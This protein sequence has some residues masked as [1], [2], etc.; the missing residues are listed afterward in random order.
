MPER[1]SWV[2][3]NKLAVG[4]FP[5]STTSAA[6]LRRQGI[7]AVLCLTEEAERAVPPEILH[8]FVWERV[9]IPDGAAGGIPTEDQFSQALKVLNRWQRKG[10]V[11]YVHCLAGVGRSASVCSLHL[12]QSQHLDL[13]EAIALVKQQHAFAAPDPHQVR[14]MQ[15]FLVSSPAN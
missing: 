8:N 3:P 14:V 2:V 15:S 11:V 9:P 10:H 12:V 5:Q 7:T 4:S 6:Q 1:F 13:G